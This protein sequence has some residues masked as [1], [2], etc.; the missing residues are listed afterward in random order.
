MAKG[1]SNGAP[2]RMIVDLGGRADWLRDRGGDHPGYDELVA[3]G[4]TRRKRVLATAEEARRRRELARQARMAAEASATISDLN[5][6]GKKIKKRSDVRFWRADVSP[7]LKPETPEAARWRARQERHLGLPKVE[8][9][10]PA[11][12]HA[13]A[14]PPQAPPIEVNTK[15]ASL[16]VPV[17]AERVRPTDVT[18]ASR[19]GQQEFRKAIIAAYGQC[20]V[21]GCR[22][23]EA[24]EAAHI[25]PYVDARS[26]LVTNGLCLRADIHRLYDRNLIQ[27]GADGVVRVDPDILSCYRDIAGSAL[28]QPGDPGER[29]NPE[30]LAVRHRFLA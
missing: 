27:I 10:K 11:T 23:E 22:V 5:T 12:R 15:A 6:N 17:P 14:R 4:S 9:P 16:P 20:A 7:P 8:H 19:E 28:I 21:T 29:P 24:L 18:Y 1:K 3:P 30:L 13:P 2:F 25:I 26:N